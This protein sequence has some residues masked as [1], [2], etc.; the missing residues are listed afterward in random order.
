MDFMPDKPLD[1]STEDLTFGTVLGGGREATTTVGPRIEPLDC[2]GNLSAA[3]LEDVAITPRTA[4]L[5]MSNG[6][7]VWAGIGRECHVRRV[8]N[9][10]DGTAIKR[11]VGRRVAFQLA[12]GDRFE[13]KREIR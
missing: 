13:S 5:V 1:M 9:N 11:R 4:L 3:D 10:L 6:K 7:H 8:S 2:G 12:T